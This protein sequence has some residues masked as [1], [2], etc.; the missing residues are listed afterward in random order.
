M[1]RKG[2]SKVVSF[3]Q[4]SERREKESSRWEQAL[5]SPGEA[6]SKVSAILSGASVP[7]RGLFEN[8]REGFCFLTVP[9]IGKFNLEL[10]QE[11]FT[12]SG[13]SLVA[14]WMRIHLTMQE[15]RICSLV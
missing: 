11:I 10:Y 14:Q 5:V 4:R 6:R 9:M 13:V 8:V 1:V 15:T 3:E 2:L 7:P 12:I